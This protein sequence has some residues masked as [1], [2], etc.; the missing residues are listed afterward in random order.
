MVRYSVVMALLLLVLVPG[1]WARAYLGVSLETLDEELVRQLG[2]DGRGAYVRDV[3][4][5]G[6]ADR[7]GIRRGD[8]IV[9]LGDDPVVGPGHLRDLLAYRRPG[10]KVKVTVWREQRRHSY[11]VTL[12]E[13]PPGPLPEALAKT[14]VIRGEPRAWLGVRTQEL[15][16]QL[17]EHF[18]VSQ[19][20]LVSEV[21]ENSPAATAGLLAG[22]VIVKL[23]ETVLEDPVDLTNALEGMEPGDKVVVTFV[24]DGKEMTKEVELGQTPKRFRR[25]LTRVFQWG[26]EDE[27]LL[28]P[29]PWGPSDPEERARLREELRVLRERLGA[30]LQ[31]LRAEL[32]ELKRHIRPTD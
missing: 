19:G 9:A 30:E 12:K 16:P 31:G 32:E 26:P 4:R 3:V 29:L 7:A 2:F 18:K 20:V 28:P 10:E 24:R 25:G 21:V 1:A 5:G 6:P 14:I 15:S 23:G 17:A 8:V 11:E 27:R 13:P 22:D